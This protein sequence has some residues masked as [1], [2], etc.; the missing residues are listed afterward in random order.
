MTVIRVCCIGDSITLGTGDAALL[1]WPGRLAQ[2]ENSR[3]HEVTLYNLGIRADTSQLIAARWL[4]ECQSRLP[5]A[6]AGGLVFAFG[7]NDTAQEADGSLRVP[8]D[9][10]VG[11]ARRM[12]TQA[13]TWKP[14][15]W[16]GPMPVEERRMPISIPGSPP[17]DFRNERI[18]ALSRHYA[19]VAAEIGV[20]YLDLFALLS[21]DRRWA[22]LLADGDG[23]HPTGAGYAFLAEVLANWPAWR[24]WFDNRPR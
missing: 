15:L 22:D 11:N 17:R 18:A 5:D 23:V 19:A 7:V 24:A 10:S 8:L 21:G 2:A 6:F 20:P 1:G 9:Q 3:G 13:S 16:L 12:M 4:A 14:T